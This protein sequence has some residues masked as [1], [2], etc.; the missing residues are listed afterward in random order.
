M[1]PLH[2]L[3]VA[4]APV[5]GLVKTRLGAEIGMEN[6]AAVAAASLLD[7]LAAC[8]EAVPVERCH[9]SLAGDLDRAVRADELRAALDGWTVHP[10]QGA[11]FGARL[12]D[13][14]AR[15][16]G[17]VV[18]VGMDTP[19]ATAEQLLDAAAGLE[20]HRAVLGPAEDGGWWVLALRDPTA[21]A[22]LAEVSMSTPTTYD[23]TRAALVAAGLDVATT[24]TLRDVDEVADAAA[25]ARLAPASRFAAAWGLVPA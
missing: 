6:A 16:P 14:H 21:A 1:T 18:Q 4:K 11:D 12:A 5:P 25:V 2:A 19:H 8:A 7:T 15:V 3:V 13:A 10:Q 24:A 20:T 17:R 9:L 23:E 22:V